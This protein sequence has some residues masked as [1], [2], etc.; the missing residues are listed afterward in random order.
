MSKG[1]NRRKYDK[2][3]DKNYSENKFFKNCEHE[4]NK[5]KKSS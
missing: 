3:N 1:S 5:Q 2:Q 4:K